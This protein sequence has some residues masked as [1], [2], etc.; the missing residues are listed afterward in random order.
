MGTES[1]HS[2]VGCRQLI[3]W[4]KCL[5][6]LLKHILF[7]FNVF[8]KQRDTGRSRKSFSIGSFLQIF[9]MARTR[10]GAQ[11]LIDKF[12]HTKIFMNKNMCIQ[13]RNHLTLLHIL[14]YKNKLHLEY[15][16]LSKILFD[17]L[18]SCRESTF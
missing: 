14:S 9:G 8:E 4:V 12:Y 17:M 1:F 3:C 13:R 5:L 2:D 10:L 15:P 7:T 11:S 16:P 6:H 18:Q